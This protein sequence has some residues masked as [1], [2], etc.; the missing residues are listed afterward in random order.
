MWRLPDTTACHRLCAHGP[1]FPLHRL[2]AD[3]AAAEAVGPVDAVDRP[4]GTRLRFATVLPS[5]ETLS[6]R[7]PLARIR[8]RRP[9]C[10]RGKSRRP[11]FGGRHRA[12]RSPSPS[13][14]RRD[15]PWPPSPRS[16]P[17]R[18][19]SAGRSLF[20]LAVARRISAGNRSD[21]SRSISTWHSGSPKRTLYSISFGPLVGDHQAGEQHALDRACPSPSS[22]ARSAAMISSIV[23][24]NICGVITGAGE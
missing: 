8:R 14:S 21:I 16:A 1:L 10:R 5:A 15:S 7:P 2:P 20:E 13:R 9:W 11:R 19:T 22:P 12:P 3:V 6:T 23:R 4:I 24:S 17:R 18:D